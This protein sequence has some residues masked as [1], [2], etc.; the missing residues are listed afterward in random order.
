MTYA[1]HS[2]GLFEKLINNDVG[3]KVE[4]LGWNTK[5]NGFR[6]KFIGV[7]EFCKKC[8]D[9]DIVVFVDGFDSLLK[10]DT[11]TVKSRFLEMNCK[12]LFSKDPLKIN[13]IF[14]QCLADG[15]VLNTGLYMGYVKYLKLLLKDAINDRCQDDQH[16]M[17][18]LCGK[19]SDIITVDTDCRI[20]KNHTPLE[21]LKTDPG[22]TCIVSYAGNM[23]GIKA[24]THRLIRSFREYSQFHIFDIVILLYSVMALFPSTRIIVFPFLIFYVIYF[25]SKADKS[26]MAAIKKYK[27]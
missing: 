20:F 26:C 15:T 25:I 3:V 27:Q 8:N 14:G 10:T 2:Q 22:D 12:T 6:D 24:Y 13:S 23:L 11:E 17:N 21:N 18:T 5:W 16:S 4:V 19:Y 9:D 1:T 7:Y